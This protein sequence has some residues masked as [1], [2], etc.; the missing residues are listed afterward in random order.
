VTDL[1]WMDRALALAE[2]GRGGTSPNPIV[3]ATIVAPDG[4]VVGDGYHERAGTP[5]AEVH[6]LAA[7]G[8]L[9]AGATLYCT[10]EPCC[11][12]G[13]TGPC[14]ERIAAAGISRVVAAVVD[15]N[16]AVAGGGIAWL[17]SR[18]I[19]VDV[20][21]RNDEARRQ[22]VA[23]FTRMRRGRPFVIFK[24]AVGIDGNIAA[25]PGARTQISGP[26]ARRR[27]Q[28]LRAEVDAIAVG[29]GTILV[30]DPLLTAREV[31]RERPLVRV[32]FDRRLRTPPSAR[33]FGT[34][35]A[36]PIVIVT[37]AAGAAQHAGRVDALRE[38]GALIETAESI[39][40]ALR[41]LARS[42]VNTVLLE[43]GAE[44]GAAFLDADLIDRVQLY[45]SSRPAG[46]PG[47]PLLAGR[48]LSTATLEGRRVETCGDDVLI[49]GDVHGTD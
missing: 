28:R 35:D 34:L 15:P 22:N 30:D 46:N 25:G 20:G 26:Q 8:P 41:S 1:D 40:D 38:A 18:G 4:E 17:R 27:V 5:H 33:M 48:P 13:R 29:S 24:A 37:D 49:E 7:A 19:I 11:H 12:Y 3:G 47:V 42:G 10:L 21:L 6:A 14:T 32:I 16:P 9:A 43:G 44:L 45:V 31:F 23:F 39:E 2:R 36:G